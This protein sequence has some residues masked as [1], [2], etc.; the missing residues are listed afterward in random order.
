[1]MN[2][3]LRKSIS[4]VVANVQFRIG[5]TTL[6]VLSK[7]AW[8]ALKKNQTGLFNRL[9]DYRKEIIDAQTAA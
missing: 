6:E 7:L 8:Q 5:G 2:T 3:E 4:E 1:M 9:V